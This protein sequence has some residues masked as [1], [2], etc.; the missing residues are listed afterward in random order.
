MKKK[1][2]LKKFIFS[3]SFSF[4]RFFF[5]CQKLILDEKCRKKKNAF[6]FF[7]FGSFQKNKK[8]NKT[9]KEKEN[10]R[11]EEMAE[12]E[13]EKRTFE[14]RIPLREGKSIPIYGLGTWTAKENDCYCSVLHALKTGHRLID[15]AQV[16]FVFVFCFCFLFF[17]FVFVF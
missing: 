12:K 9:K 17:V 14:T 6:F 13:E 4:H 11:E 5:S 3:F 7:F 15:T 2:F 10:E 16:F 8:Q 1:E